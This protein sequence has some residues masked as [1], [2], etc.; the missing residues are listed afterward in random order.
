MEEHGPVHLT[1]RRSPPP[2]S[3]PPPSRFRDFA[4]RLWR[5]LQDN[6]VLNT[7]ALIALASIAFRFYV[8]VF[9]NYSA[10]YGSLAAVIILLLWLYLA[11][12]A[13]LVGC[14]IDAI[15][16]RRSSGPWPSSGSE[17]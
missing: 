10:T 15:L 12:I 1:R 2:T 11:G 13:L 9:G 5:E 7:A 4:K 6:D 16:Y 14:Q 8:S 17:P 3:P